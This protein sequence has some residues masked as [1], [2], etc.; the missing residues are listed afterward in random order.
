MRRKMQDECAS[1]IQ[2][3]S[4]T[5][6]VDPIMIAQQ[7]I[8]RI[9][10]GVRTSE[11][12]E[13]AAKICASMETTNPDYGEL[14]KRIIISNNHKNTSPSFSTCAF[15]AIGFFKYKPACS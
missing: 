5:L 11:L 10:D 14:A 7:V 1:N 4:G 9:Y 2:S 15:N 3:L 13:L 6:S 8:S 12:D